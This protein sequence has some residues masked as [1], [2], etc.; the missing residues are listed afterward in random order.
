[1]NE[2][3]V[4]TATE[5]RSILKNDVWKLVYRPDNKNI[6]GSRVILANKYQPDGC[7]QKGKARIVARGFGQLPGVDFDETFAPVAR[8]RSIRLAIAIAAH[9]KM[10]I[11]HCDITTA[12]LN[13]VIKEEVYMEIPEF[14][15]ETLEKLISTESHKS[16]IKLNLKRNVKTIK[17]WE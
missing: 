15:E 5:L 16:C 14:P 17:N 1:M 3:Y 8:L 9:Y 11:H 10:H 2:W 12:Y 6:I 4:A 13:S 7:V